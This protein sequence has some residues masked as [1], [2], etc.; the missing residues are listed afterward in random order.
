MIITDNKFKSSTVNRYEPSNIHEQHTA[1]IILKRSPALIASQKKYYEKNKEKITKKQTEYNNKYFKEIITCE[2][3]IKHSRAAKYSHLKSQRHHRRID[4]MK[5]GKLAGS[6]PGDVRIECP[7]G[8]HYLVK[9]RQQHFRTNKHMKYQ[10]HM[11]NKEYQEIKH[12]VQEITHNIP[13]VNEFNIK[14]I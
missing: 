3:G 10:I 6:T 1:T 7:C 5:A 12:S 8:G 13:T 2:C 4:N 14:E 9:L 11:K